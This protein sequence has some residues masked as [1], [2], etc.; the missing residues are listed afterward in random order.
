MMKIKLGKK[1]DLTY[2]KDQLHYTNEG[3][4]VMLSSFLYSRYGKKKIEDINRL[5]TPTIN[6]MELVEDFNSGLIF[7]KNG[8][9]LHAL[10]KAKKIFMDAYNGDKKI[11]IITDYDCDG[12]NSAVISQKLI[13]KFL[14]KDK[15]K[16][17]VNKR[18]FGNGVNKENFKDINMEDYSLIITA[19]QGSSNNHMFLLLKD[20][21]NDL[22][23]IVTDH[24]IIPEDQP[25]TNA[26]VVLNNMTDKVLNK[27][28]SGCYTM[29]FFMFY[30]LH[31]EFKHSQFDILYHVVDNIM[32]T[33][34]SD[35]M[36]VSEPVNRMIYKLALSKMNKGESE[37]IN[38]LRKHL[39]LPDLISLDDV[40]FTI[41]PAINSGN[42][43]HK[44]EI[45]YEA[46]YNPSSDALSGLLELNEKRKKLTNIA[47]QRLEET[48]SI[49]LNSLCV[50]TLKTNFGI[51][52]IIAGKLGEKYRRPA[53]CFVKDDN[54]V[55]HGSCRSIIPGLNMLA[56]IKE[57]SDLGLVDKFGGHEVAVGC[58]IREKNYP[59]F[60]TN[61]E[62]LVRNGIGYLSNV[63]D[64]E[65]D[66]VI[67][68]DD[69]DPLD[70][71]S[72]DYFEPYGN[73]FEEPTFYT[74]VH[75]DSAYV[76]DTIARIKVMNSYRILDFIAF[77]NIKAPLKEI[78]RQGNNVGIV[79]KPSYSF[80]RGNLNMKLL[81][82]KACVL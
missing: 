57:L 18:L 9:E 24:H 15:F 38:N 7:F 59:E 34:I 68:V 36:N 66:G 22:K 21:Y 80:Y 25:P 48:N 45:A 42:R 41:C 75:I 3:L 46:L 62:V 65:I 29:W 51:N 61:I 14:N 71:T 30:I 37:I 50:A 2:N 60:L 43:L 58:T 27:N 10:E 76:T 82:T 35:V 70:I 20:E 17:I 73:G 12:I 55:M 54:G 33:I 8:L 64:I 5:N 4:G 74:E 28:L 67:N 78:F 49:Y 69:I 56:I 40:R 23:I 52:G 11:L 39:K 26:D 13:D 77:N 19:D 79:F 53:I 47:L 1:I 16:I 31:K 81:I 6:L 44:E 63:D 32:L 72:F